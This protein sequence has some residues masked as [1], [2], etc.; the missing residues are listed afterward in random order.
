V[1][2]RTVELI[3]GATNAGARLDTL[4]ANHPEIASRASAQRLIDSGR[5]AVGG[6]ARPKGYRVG[7]GEQ[8]VAGIDG[9]QPD[10]ASDPVVAPHRVVYEDDHLIIVDKP[11][12][13]VVHPGA[14]HD[15]GTLAQ[16]LAGR[17]AGGDDPQRAGIVQRLDRDTSGLM[18][19]AKSAAAHGALK[20]LIRERRIER[21]YLALVE[22]R[23]DARSGTIDAPIGRDATRR[24]LISTRTARPR[25]ALTH[26]DQVELFARA[27]LLGVRLETGRTHQIRVHLAA[28]GHPVCGD[29]R[30]GGG[31]C[32]ERLGLGRQFLHSHRLAFL[33]PFSG[34]SLVCT[35]PPPADLLRALEAARRER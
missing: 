22:G 20:K 35:S 14:G 23:P 11:A 12:G 26:F 8:I 33:H 19:V 5:V 32:G 9:A 28:I 29:A 31:A 10:P 21:E 3:V 4:L 30:Y 13:V 15:R 18:T 7:A 27:S 16:A 1:T 6:R 25:A 17:A 34:K 24:T 2:D